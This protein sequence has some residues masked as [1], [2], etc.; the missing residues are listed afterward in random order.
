MRSKPPTFRFLLTA[1]LLLTLICTLQLHQVDAQVLDYD[2]LQFGGDAQHSG[3]NTKENIIS[4]ST[5]KNLKRLFQVKLPAVVDGPP[6][7]LRLVRTRQGIRDLLFATTIAGDLLALDALTGSLIWR[8]SH[9]AVNCFILNNKAKEL[10]CDTASI[11]AIDPNLRYVY[12]Y[13][14]DGYVHKHQ[15][16][17]G[18]EVKSQGWPQLV[19][20][21]PW[22]EKSS[23]ALSIATAQNGTSY[24]YVTTSGYPDDLG[25]YQGHLTTI[26]LQDGS[27]KVF[28]ALCGHQTVHLQERPTI[29]YCFRRRA[30]IWGR[31]G[32]V[33]LPATDR[34]YLT[35]DKGDFRPS[36]G[37]WGNSVIALNPDGSGGKNNLPL[38][39]YTPLNF[40]E[41]VDV[42]RALAMSHPLII[43]APAGSK[44]KFLA[45]QEGKDHLLRVLDAE[46]L[47]GRGKTGYAGGEIGGFAVIPF[48]DIQL[49]TAA[50]TW[51]NPADNTPWIFFPTYLGFS[52]WQVVVDDKGSPSLKM[53]W[54][55]G[56]A[57]VTPLIANNILYTAIDQN[58]RAFDPLT[59]KQ[60]WGDYPIGDIHWQSPIV[61]NGILYITDDNAQLTAYSLDGVAPPIRF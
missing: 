11:P 21:K 50:A 13:S 52:A 60:L 46:N 44:F 31:G 24:L 42:D 2:W 16:G 26:N 32:V 7:Y 15:V 47:N 37:N 36:R 6:V 8:Q 33:Y 41:L 56:D 49:D 58:I 38:D 23:T 20:L 39:N 12:S 9:P 59:G 35:T 34:I 19:T 25:D 1:V 28:N 27:Q 55:N 29:P 48:G 14:P 18:T 43:P 17:N 4:V 51:T 54:K 22:V 53:Q 57:G 40:Q 3:N 10:P 45:I 61:V 30:G 5:I